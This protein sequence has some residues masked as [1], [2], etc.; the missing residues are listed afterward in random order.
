MCGKAAER[1]ILFENGSYTIA[2]ALVL[3]LGLLILIIIFRALFFIITL[4]WSEETL[5]RTRAVDQH[6]A[7]FQCQRHT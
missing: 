2:N 1:V 5:T 3:Q 6:L 7:L 4:T